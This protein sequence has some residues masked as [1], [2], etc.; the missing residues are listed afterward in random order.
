[1]NHVDR[2]VSYLQTLED[3][4]VLPPA[5]PYSHIGAA[6]VDAVLQ[7]GLNYDNVVRQRVDAVAAIGSART[8]KGFLQ[9]LE[10]QG[11][12]TVLS[13]RPGRKPRLVVSLAELLD[14]EGVN[15]VL[16]LHAWL[17]RPE[18]LP[19]L[20]ALHGV[21]P[22]TVDY[23]KDLV[24]LPAVAID[25]HLSRL[26]LAAG[27]PATDYHDARAIIEGAFD[28]MGVNRSALD[29]SIWRFMADARGA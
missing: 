21:G 29:Y 17:Q 5:E 11:V 3:F 8:T 14:R 7:A 13:W 19:K 22:K 1:M 23:L 15:T 18:N 25:V 4:R 12:E 6:I 24:G 9:L 2:V 27:V 28:R 10:A 16:D 20:T 26:L